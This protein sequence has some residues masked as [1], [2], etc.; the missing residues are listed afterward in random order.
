MIY[1][2]SFKD[3]S[4]LIDLTPPFDKSHLTKANI[5]VPLSRPS[6][7]SRVKL[8][9]PLWPAGDD[10]ARG[11]CINKFMSAMKPNADFIIEMKRLKDLA[12]ATK[13]DWAEF[14][15]PSY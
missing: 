6:L 9:R 5:L 14:Y 3:E 12:Q 11:E 4:W 8:L 7:W 10:A 15:V 1:S 13:R 2:V